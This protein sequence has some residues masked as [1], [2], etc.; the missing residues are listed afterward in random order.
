MPKDWSTALK[1]SS[2]RVDDEI[3]YILRG[4]YVGADLH[5]PWFFV[6]IVTFDSQSE[7]KCAQKGLK[8]KGSMQSCAFH[9]V[10]FF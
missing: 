4:S 9:G 10:L 5:G 1:C 7:P 8:K 3:V 2:F 6:F